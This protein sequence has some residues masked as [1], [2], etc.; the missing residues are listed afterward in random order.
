MHKKDINGIKNTYI[1]HFKHKRDDRERNEYYTF[2]LSSSSSSLHRLTV[3]SLIC[4][5]RESEVESFLWLRIPSVSHPHSPAA[6]VGAVEL[7]PVRRQRSLWERPLGAH[8][9]GEAATLWSPW[10]IAGFSNLF[11]KKHLPWTLK[12]PPKGR[13]VYLFASLP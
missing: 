10:W 9:A 3:A 12:R 1:K 7:A 5:S 8:L 13:S 11:S 2:S 6:W 4:Y